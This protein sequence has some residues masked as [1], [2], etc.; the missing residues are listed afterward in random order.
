MSIAT[1]MC[2]NPITTLLKQLQPYKTK[3][4]GSDWDPSEYSWAMI[5]AYFSMLSKLGKKKKIKM[6]D[7]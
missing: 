6:K 1:G 5:H 4:I 2:T 7:L 3:G